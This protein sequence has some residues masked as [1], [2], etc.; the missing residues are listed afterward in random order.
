MR[1]QMKQGEIAG[2]VESPFGFHIIRVTAVKGSGGFEDVKKQVETDLRRQ[3]AGKRFSELS[4]QFNNLVFEQGDSLKPAAEA[5][6]VPVQQS[7]W[8]SRDGSGVK[9]LDNPKLLQAVFSDDIVKNKRNTEVVDVGNNTLV[10]ARIL[11]YKPGSVRPFEDVVA[12]ITRRLTLQQSAQLAS[13]RR[14]SSS[15]S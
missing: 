15:P 3:K 12:E 10:A 11:E 5:L 14:V 9:L 8:I 13:K 7:G 2:P 4:E 6:K 1:F